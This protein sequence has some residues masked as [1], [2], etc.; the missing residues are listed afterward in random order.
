MFWP[1]G[2]DFF[3][4]YTLTSFYENSNLIVWTMLTFSKVPD[5]SKN[6]WSTNSKALSIFLDVT[7]RSQF[8]PLFPS[9]LKTLRAFCCWKR[10]RSVPCSVKTWSTTGLFQFHGSKLVDGTPEMQQFV[11]ELAMVLLQVAY[12]GAEKVASYGYLVLVQQAKNDNVTALWRHISWGVPF[13]MVQPRLMKDQG[14]T[15]NTERA[16]TL[17]EHDLSREMKILLR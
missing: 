4:A 14:C 15:W 6:T 1:E 8:V 5:L 2:N 13:G 12:Y 9:Q 10:Q 3:N 16:N 11:S 7:M 17:L